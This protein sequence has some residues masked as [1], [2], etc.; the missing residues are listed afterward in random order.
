MEPFLTSEIS[1]YSPLRI[2]LLFF[3]ILI[4]LLIGRLAKFI[5]NK[6]GGNLKKQDRPIAAITF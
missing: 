1:G 5:L 2:T 3:I 6:T 4:A